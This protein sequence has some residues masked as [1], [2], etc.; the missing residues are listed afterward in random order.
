[1]ANVNEALPP[2]VEELLELQFVKEE[3]IDDAMPKQERAAKQVGEVNEVQL[4]AEQQAA[5]EDLLVNYEST[6]DGLAQTVMPDEVEMDELLAPVID[7][8]VQEDIIKSEQALQSRSV[9][10]SGGFMDKLI[11]GAG[12]LVDAISLP[13]QLAA[14]AGKAVGEAVVDAT[15]ATYSVGKGLGETVAGVK[16]ATENMSAIETTKS[17]AGIGYLAALNTPKATAN[18]GDFLI[19]SARRAAG[20]SGDFHGFRNIV[21]QAYDF[22]GLNGRDDAESYAAITEAITGQADEA[23]EAQLFAGRFLGNLASI[24]GAMG[25]TNRAMGIKAG[26]YGNKSQ[27]TAYEKASSL[28]SIGI[29]PIGEVA[30]QLA[31][32]L[33]RNVAQAATRAG[34]GELAFLGA[35]YEDSYGKAVDEYLNVYK[36]SPKWSWGLLLGGTAFETI[37]TMRQAKNTLNQLTRQANSVFKQRASIKPTTNFAFGEQVPNNSIA[38]VAAKESGKQL[39]QVEQVITA[40]LSDLLAKGKIDSKLFSDAKAELTQMKSMNDQMSKQL[41]GKLTKNPREALVLSNLADNNP[42]LLAATDSIKDYKTLLKNEP[43]KAGQNLKSISLDQIND[44]AKKNPQK[45]YF[46]VHEDGT[47][48][49][50]AQIK[51]RFIDHAKKSDFTSDASGFIQYRVGK[52]GLLNTLT[53]DPRVTAPTFDT[54]EAYAYLIKA[55]AEKLGKVSKEGQLVNKKIIESMDKMAPENPWVANALAQLI[56]DQPKIASKMVLATPKSYRTMA[57][58][59]TKNYLLR[60]LDLGL[61]DDLVAEVQK[62]GYEVTDQSKFVSRLYKGQLNRDVNSSG[63]R[64]AGWNKLDLTP[65]DKLVIEVDS[66]KLNEYEQ[67]QNARAISEANAANFSQQLI[68]IGQQNPALRG[69]ADMFTKN[70]LVDQVRQVDD[71]VGSHLP[72]AL[73]NLFS[74]MYN[75]IGDTTMAA[76]NRLTEL[77]NNS[78]YKYLT[79]RLQPLK[80]V[81]EK[82]GEIEKVQLNKFAK[83]TKMGFEI[84]DDFTLKTTVKVVNG[85]QIEMLTT[86]NAIAIDRA[87]QIGLLTPD[88]AN[89]YR[90]LETTA[91]PDLANIAEG[92]TLELSESTEEF[93]NLYKSINNELY[94]GRKQIVRAFGGNAQYTQPFHIANKLG[95]EVNFIYD[96]DQLISTVT[97]NSAKEL[98]AAT[99]K[100]LELLNQYAPMWAGKGSKLQVKSRA[101][102]QRDHLIDPD[103]EWLGWVNAAGEYSK[104]KY[105]S[106][107]LDRTSI[108]L[109]FEYDPDIA[110]TLYNDLIKRGQGLGKMYQGAFFN[111]EAQYAKMLG[112]NAGTSP[113]VR[114]AIREYINLL[115]G[116]SVNTSPTVQKFN[117]VV[118][119][120]YSSMCD[121]H[122]SKLN[123]Q[124]AKDLKIAD[125]QK[126][127]ANVIGKLP[128]ANALGVTHK[129]QQLVNWSLLRFGRMSQAVLNVLGVVPMSHFATMSLNPTKWEDAASYAARVGFYGREVDMTRRWGT[130]DWLGAFFEATKKQF[131]KKGKVILQLAEKQGYV[132]RDANMLRDIV[133]EPTK[134]AADSGLFKQA[135]KLINKGATAA[136]DQTEELSRSFSFLM[137]H[138]LAGRAGLK[139]QQMRFIFAKQFSD[140]V[141]GNYSVLNK[142]NVYRGAVPALLGT[143]K[144]Y[145]LNVMQQLLDAYSLGNASVL[146][147]FGTQYLTFGLNSLPFSQLAQNVIFP[148]EGEEDTYSYLRNILGSDSAARAAMYTLGSLVDTDLSS[149][150]D[151]DPVT[152]GFLPINGSFTLQDIS[153][154]VSMLDDSVNLVK[155]MYGAM[156]SEVGLSAHRLQELISQYSPVSSIRAFAKLGN[157]MYDENGNEF[158]YSVD[159]NGNVQRINSLVT[160]LG[161]NSIEQAENWRLES[162][163]RARDAINQEKLNDLRKAFK[164]G[165]RFLRSG[166]V[167]IDTDLITKAFEGYIKSGGSLDAFIPWAQAQ[168][169]AATM[170]KVDRQ[171]ELL[172]SKDSI[173]AFNDMQKLM[174]ASSYEAYRDL[175]EPLED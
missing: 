54:A 97:A 150:G 14:K 91:L 111:R 166:N 78:M 19:N 153:P 144:T 28:A 98:K 110:S 4:Q 131:S 168:Y 161:F 132:S 18:I 69:L 13:A 126:L 107:R 47:V 125:E 152:G 157:Q 174:S 7:A 10:S 92:K 41:L 135:L 6:P 31:I 123:D 141:V 76:V 109:A 85:E 70:P 108:G 22:I 170:T 11:K 65:Q 106:G 143:F 62:F 15:K 24:G 105:N 82:L 117:E 167:Q 68:D 9:D 103:E 73:G 95:S 32:P 104:L 1:M 137:G 34:V 33:S 120:F 114:T 16:V 55:N 43:V 112:E 147:A 100:E 2:E 155:D 99:A 26:W 96:G 86:R 45:S 59:F 8:K 5:I 21:D 87:E 52:K 122:S 29:K 77:S 38:F 154:V 142:P 84:G 88:Q 35:S 165:F 75:Y 172:G 3:I 83:L 127:M 49:P 94:S 128:K 164:A 145:K 66:A 71:I 90:N 148:V 46:V 116:R 146:K 93:L 44:H 17:I 101:D 124:I 134:V 115:N 67:M 139:T 58:R 37:A 81:G 160:A 162:R 149:R 158:T 121:L 20:A 30:T 151:I 89:S 61:A 39:S 48:T 42:M 102:V 173:T 40:D 36:E 130:V 64:D 171:I 25:I 51:P 113:E 118:D 136:A 60:K 50:A 63:L 23:N 175:F 163:M 27:W 138:E 79:D 159:R 140:N 53:V 133:F 169:N 74:K 12:S 72:R 156:K 80:Q 57:D 129:L 56:E 119:S